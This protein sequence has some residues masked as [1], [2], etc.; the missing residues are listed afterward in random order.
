[1]SQVAMTTH[2]KAQ[3]QQS[4]FLAVLVRATRMQHKLGMP[5]YE[6]YVLRL[7]HW[8]VT[9]VVQSGTCATGVSAPESMQTACFFNIQRCICI[10]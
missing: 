4:K 5:A 9:S 1:M 2:S 3:R 6:L 7:L 8:G 10:R